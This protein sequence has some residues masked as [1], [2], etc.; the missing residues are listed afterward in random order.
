L[1]F[2]LRSFRRKGEIE[3][4]VHYAKNASDNRLVVK[5]APLAAKQPLPWSA[6][7]ASKLFYTAIEYFEENDT[8]Q[9]VKLYEDYAYECYLTNQLQDAIIYQGRALNMGGKERSGAFGK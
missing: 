9:L 7:E 2:F 5:Y 4:I 1:N 3:K 6:Y 8:D